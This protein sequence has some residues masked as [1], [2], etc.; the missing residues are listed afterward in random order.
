MADEL[1]G[2][3][4]G[5]LRRTSATQGTSRMNRNAVS[6][7]EFDWSENEL[8]VKTSDVTPQTEVQMRENTSKRKPVV[9]P[10]PKWLRTAVEKETV[11]SST[12]NA[13]SRDQSHRSTHSDVDSGIGSTTDSDLR[14]SQRSVGSDVTTPTIVFERCDSIEELPPERVTSEYIDEAQ[15]QNILAG[16]SVS[17]FQD[18]VTPEELY[19]V[20]D[21]PKSQS[22]YENVRFL[23]VRRSKASRMS[24]LEYMI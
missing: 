8:Y 18:D 12:E 1:T 19:D 10:K 22:T 17:V 6:I 2:L 16:R 20:V 24:K 4:A 15:L 9:S 3:S 13:P 11:T 23:S 5:A 14:T 7:P 21:P